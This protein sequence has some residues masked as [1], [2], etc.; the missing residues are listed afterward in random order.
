MT[1]A[2]AG[3]LR[4]QLIPHSPSNHF[5]QGVKTRRRLLVVINPHG[6]PVSFML[7]VVCLDLTG[8]VVGKSGLTFQE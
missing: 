3:A 2:Y 1:A 5:S 8:T 6:G 7:F 4:V